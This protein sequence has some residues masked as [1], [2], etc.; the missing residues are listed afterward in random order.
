[1]PAGHE[2]WLFEDNLIQLLT[3][4]FEVTLYFVNEAG[5]SLKFG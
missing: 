4:G 1:M 5:V 2:S 3:S